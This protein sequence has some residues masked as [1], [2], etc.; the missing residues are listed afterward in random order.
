VSPLDALLVRH[1]LPTWRIVAW[2]IVLLLIA[3]IVWSHF[4]ELEE[5][6]VAPGEVV[7]ENR[8]KVIQH[9]EGGIIDEIFVSE[10]S[11]V[12]AGDPLVRLNLAT[13]GLNRNEL[14]AQLDGQ[15]LR[16]ARLL[17]ETRGTE[18]EPPAEAAARHP[19]LAETEQHAFEALKRELASKQG[20]LEE[21]LHQRQLEVQELEARRRATVANLALARERLK[22]SSSLLAEGLTAKMEHLQLQ[23]EVEKLE[24]EAQSLTPAVPR[25]RAAV[26]EAQQRLKEGIEHFRREA[27]EQLGETE[28]TIARLNEQL[29]QAVDQHRRAEIRSPID[30]IVKKLRYHTLGGVVA[31]GEPIMEIVPTSDTLVVLAHLDPSDRGYVHAGLPALVKITTYDYVRY[32]GLKGHVVQVA[33]DS[34]TDNQGRS[35]F[36]VVVETDRSHLGTDK[37]PLPISTGMQASVDI[38]TGRRSVMD[39]LLKPVLKMRD[40]A[41]H[42][43]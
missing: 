34:T 25:A 13:A 35:Y 14:Q 38:H 11:V 5:V 32:G 6:A 40:E 23:A 3:L 30:G 39:Y 7:P 4:A 2:P 8:V 17:A 41:L 1:P 43:R 19:E 9:L 12:H 21:Q 29:A 26:G 22:M 24:G 31:P 42:E 27:Q 15:M 16:R 20:V 33:P 10:G 37:T 36:E 18:I 28:D